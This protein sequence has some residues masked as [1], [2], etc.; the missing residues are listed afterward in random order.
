MCYLPNASRPLKGH[1]W[2]QLHQ[3]ATHKF[4]TE[5]REQAERF[6]ITIYLLGSETLSPQLLAGS[7]SGVL[8]RP[9]HSSPAQTASELP[10]LSQGLLHLDG[11]SQ[12]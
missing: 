12:P 2:Y 4:Q 9:P 5:P 11:N 7:M 3:T 6:N 1:G 8:G 10:E